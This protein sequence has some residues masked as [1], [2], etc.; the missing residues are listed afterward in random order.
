MVGVH[1]APAVLLA[2][3]SLR[4]ALEQVQQAREGF[5]GARQEVSL[6]LSGLQYKTKE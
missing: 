4:Q 2:V 1:R 5:R 3:R 6:G